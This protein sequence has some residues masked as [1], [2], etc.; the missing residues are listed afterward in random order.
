[1][2]HY[3]GWD[4]EF[5]NA[6]KESYQPHSRKPTVTKGTLEDDQRRR[7]FTINALAIHLNP[8]HFGELIDPFQGIQDLQDRLLRTPLDPAKTFSDDPLRMMRAI[9]RRALYW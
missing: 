4:V 8:S 5:V 3:Q 7:D 2:V 9:P 6:R 1:M